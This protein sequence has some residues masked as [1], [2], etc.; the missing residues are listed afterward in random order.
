MGFGIHLKS[1]NLSSMGINPPTDDCELIYT[2]GLLWGLAHV[3][4][5]AEKSHNLQA[6]E[7]G[8]LS[9]IIPT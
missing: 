6:G 3:I 1:W 2:R 4:Q 5:K 8:K 9:G 7:P